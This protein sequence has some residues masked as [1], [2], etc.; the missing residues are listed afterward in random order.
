M[1]EPGAVQHGTDIKNSGEHV[2][3]WDH[4]CS[5]WFYELPG[6]PTVKSPALCLV[7]LSALLIVVGYF[8]WGG[9]EKWMDLEWK[10]HSHISTE[11]VV[12][13]FLTFWTPFMQWSEMY[14]MDLLFLIH[15][16]I[17]SSVTSSLHGLRFFVSCSYFRWSDVFLHGST[18]VK[19]TPF[20]DFFFC[21]LYATCA[22]NGRKSKLFSTYLV[23][24]KLSLN[25]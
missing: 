6:L 19:F 24:C 11:H 10:Q 3:L 9:E 4:Y 2:S 13:Q 16:Q 12:S 21:Q 1:K 17:Q 5:L 8:F 7:R 18:V 20:E 25:V 15:L 22:K 23:I 14:E